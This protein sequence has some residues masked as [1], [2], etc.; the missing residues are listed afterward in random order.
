MPTT[1]LEEANAKRQA[2]TIVDR[3]VLLHDLA[4]AG[5]IRIVPAVYNLATG[6]VQF[7]QEIEV[8]A[9]AVAQHH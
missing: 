6:K 7:F 2:H 5:K 4:A 9:T 3:S 8:K 1:R